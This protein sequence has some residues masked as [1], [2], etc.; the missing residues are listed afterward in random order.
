M[1]VL[2]AAAQSGSK[3]F[4]TCIY[5]KEHTI[6]SLQQFLQNSSYYFYLVNISTLCSWEQRLWHIVAHCNSRFWNSF[7]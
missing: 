7:C 2:I 4:Y 6:A 5:T 3:L 1:S